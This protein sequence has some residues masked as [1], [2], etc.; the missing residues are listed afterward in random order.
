MGIPGFADAL[1][2]EVGLPIETGLVAAAD[3]VGPD[4]EPGRMV[5]AAGL[6]VAEAAA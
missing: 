2:A 5:V 4:V 3:S 1:A 6:A